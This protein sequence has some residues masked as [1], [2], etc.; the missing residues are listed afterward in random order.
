MN[1]IISRGLFTTVAPLLIAAGFWYHD[2]VAVGRQRSA[3]NHGKARRR[4]TKEQKRVA[5]KGGIQR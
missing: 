1:L 2:T 4:S 5:G 3:P